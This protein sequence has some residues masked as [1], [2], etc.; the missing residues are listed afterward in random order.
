MVTVINSFFFPPNGSRT[1]ALR[2]APALRGIRTRSGPRR[3]VGVGVGVGAGAGTSCVR[4][5]QTAPM[6]SASGPEEVLHSHGVPLPRPC[7]PVRDPGR[8]A[9]C[10]VTPHLG[11]VA[12][13][14]L[15][16]SHLMGVLWE[17]CTKMNDTQLR[18]KPA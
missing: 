15:T 6:A 17:F 9:P 16:L 7:V 12:D 13:H 14:S 4:T 8:R 18:F 11:L 1:P 2:V 10:Q 5:R 3:E